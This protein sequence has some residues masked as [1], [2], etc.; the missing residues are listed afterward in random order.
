MSL[1][2]FY[3]SYNERILVIELKRYAILVPYFAI[4]WMASALQIVVVAQN[5]D[6]NFEV[7]SHLG[8]LSKIRIHCTKTNDYQRGF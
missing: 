1:L 7:F 5:I 3:Q 8:W 6:T 2:L 4:I